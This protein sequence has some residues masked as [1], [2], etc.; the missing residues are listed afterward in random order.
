[1]K[2]SRSMTWPPTLSSSLR[3][4]WCVFLLENS[5]GAWWASRHP[6]SP[7]VKEFD[8]LRFG[9]DSLPAAGGFPGWPERA[10]EITVMDPCCGSGHF[11]VAAFEMIRRMRME[12]EDLGETEAADAVLRDNLFGLEVDPRCVQIAAFS[13]ALTAWKVAGYRELP[14]LN[15]ACSGMGGPWA[16]RSVDEAGRRRC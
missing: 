2:R 11:L 7:L 16:A 13:L 4:T 15:V 1:M 14:S 12:E 5:L 8:Y 3:T 9:D 6:N 10:A